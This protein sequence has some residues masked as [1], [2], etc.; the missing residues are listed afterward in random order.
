MPLTWN[1]ENIINYK[2]VCWIETGEQREDGTPKTRL[3]PVTEA[4][5]WNSIAID[6][7]EITHDNAS[8]V[9]ARTRI[10]EQINGPLMIRDGKPSPIT[11]E[12]IEAHVGLTVNVSFKSRKEWALRTFVGNGD[13]L[14]KYGT[15][16][17][18]S[19]YEQDQENF[20]TPI[21]NSMTAEF[22]RQFDKDRAK[23]S[24]ELADM[25]LSKTASKE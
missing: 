15:K 4:L 18:K 1:V 8:E 23:R 17:N 21:D 2:T 5:I 11:T 12:E 9:Y 3:N 7:G 25:I 24:K 14:M 19:K 10:M 16:F 6:I 20:D 13:Y 22:R